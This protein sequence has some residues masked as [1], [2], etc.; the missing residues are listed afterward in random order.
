MH[1]ALQQ[2]KVSDVTFKPLSVGQIIAVPLGQIKRKHIYLT[3]FEANTP[4]VSPE[5]VYS[6][7]PRK[8][9]KSDN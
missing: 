6:F 8:D 7:N 5:E 9:F 4:Q 1:Y 2:K 3:L